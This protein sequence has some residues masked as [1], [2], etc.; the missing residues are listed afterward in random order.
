MLNPNHSL[1]LVLETIFQPC[2]IL[3]FA[4]HTY[5]NVDSNDK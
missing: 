1:N 4:Y 3:S 5:A 2:P